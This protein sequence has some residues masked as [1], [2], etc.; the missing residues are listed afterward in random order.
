MTDA[1]ELCHHCGL[2]I[3][4]GEIVTEERG[5]KTLGFC[6]RGCL[7]AYRI[8]H[9]AGLDRFYRERNWQEPGTPAGAFTIDFDDAALAGQ[10]VTTPG[11]AEIAFLLEGIR[12]AT[13]VWLNEKVLTGLPGVTEA[14]VNYATHRVRVR[15]DPNRTSP[16]AL[17]AA[18]S[19]LGYR[20]RPDSRQA[21]HQARQ[22]QRRSLLIRFGTAAFLSL[23]LMGFSLALYGGYFRGM[24]A[25]TRQLLQIFA[26]AVTT[27]VVF[28]AG[29]PF[30]QG[31]W[32]SLRNGVP[33]MDLLVAL[34]VLAAYGYSLYALASGGEVYFDSAAMI[35]TLILLG[36]L[37]EN[38]ARQQ[39]AAGIERLLELA[40]DTALRL[41]AEGPRP[42][43]SAL[44][45]AG[46]LVLVRPGDRVPVDGAIVD[47]T[48]EVDEAVVTGEVLPVLRQ[49]G[50]RLVSGSLN[51]T[52]A[53]TLRAACGARDSFLA[54]ITRLVEEAQARTAPVQ[55]LADR[56]AAR[57]VPGVILLAGGTW[58]YWSWQG[59]GPAQPL[60]HAVAVLVVA[61]PCALGL[62]TPTAVLVAT[63]TGARRGIFFRGG[64]ILEKL[65]RL[66]QVAFDK[67]G[68]L[69]RGRPEVVDIAPAEPGMTK[70]ALLE[71][72]AR[73]ESGSAHPLARGILE[74][75]A[76]QGVTVP[77][78]GGGRVHPGMGIALE[79]AEGRL[80]VGNREFLAEAGVAVPPSPASALTEVLVARDGRFLGAIHL[81]DLPRQGAAEL[82]TALRQL[83][84]GTTL[85]T[86]DRPETGAR[87]ATALG[88]DASHG[89]LTPAMK[90]D[91]VAARQ[92]AG[93]G[94]LMVGD[95]INDAP[96]LA[97]AEV[98][99]AMA[100]G[101]DIALESSD[102]V[103]TRPDLAGVGVALRLARRTLGIIRQNLFW[104]FLYNLLALPLAASG[105][106]AP[107]HAAAAMA[108]SS[109]CV[110][111]NSL[112]LASRRGL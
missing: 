41:D 108:L 98:G 112:R 110:V 72:A 83:G 39:A 89:A 36:R 95:G 70:Q 45:Q 19:A 55:R 65:G 58:A 13:C 1:Q 50:D 33:N 25:G 85:L 49:P 106:L 43:E 111:G 31:A 61:C 16:G 5:T 47:G 69:T 6:C 81:E 90:A 21:E 23:Q 102:L 27:P 56:L 24:D 51:L 94:V 32:R 88:L 42:V 97:T 92:A 74:A 4:P 60:L 30:L 109:V 9:G 34:G 11:G 62:A 105:R 10:V 91:W 77:L 35:V 104:A 12:C 79:T 66:E 38:G 28:Y 2:P 54:R 78:T 20:P 18:V 3:P 26:A 100:G 86:G 15:F 57:F 64:D 84:L 14:R 103:L 80:L 8:I 99:C 37:L 87:L 46:D 17:F 53:V 44:L 40:P 93:Q 52:T 75:A 76:R 67:T 63:G 96:A 82:V 71:L 68:T 22:A 59:A 73:A 7:G 101:T 29:A 48:T 107:I